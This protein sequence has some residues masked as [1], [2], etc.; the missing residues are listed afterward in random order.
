MNT[1]TARIRRSFSALTL[2]QLAMIGAAMAVAVA[3]RLLPHPPN[4]TPMA[5]IGLFAGAVCLRPAVAASA[6]VGAML[7]SDAFLGFHS[8]MPVVYGCLLVN[9]A[10]GSRFVRGA[11]GLDFGAASCG[12]M[13]AGSLIGSVLF[14]LATNFAHFVAF[15]PP[16]F[17]GLVACYT[18]A[19]PFFQFTVAGDLVYAGVLFGSFA[20][21][22]M[23]SGAFAGA[24][25]FVAQS[26]STR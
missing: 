5:A 1:L 21:V 22:S 4:F 14:F 9:L 15:Y 2:S 10:I 18:A 24:G 25:R 17:S 3:S 20:L 23:K 12:R 6:I 8:L 16:T 7:I 13:I 11:N 19:I 26:A